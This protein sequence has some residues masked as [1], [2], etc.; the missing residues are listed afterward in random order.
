MVRPDLNTWGHTPADLRRL[1][2]NAQHPRSR[3]RLLA[4][5]MIASQQTNA[6]SWAAHIGRAKE[7]VLN[8]VHQYNLAGL[9]GVIYRHTGGRRPLLTKNN[10]VNS[11]IRSS[12]PS[13]STM[14]CRATPGH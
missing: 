5:Y 13:R 12:T 4:L 2:V 9:D 14:A 8:W 3:E 1:A 11:S 6:T 10:W 7:T